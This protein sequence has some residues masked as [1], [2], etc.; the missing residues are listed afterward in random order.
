MTS[1][2]DTL[3]VVTADHAHT[4]AIVGYASRGNPILGLYHITSSKDHSVNLNM[5]TLSDIR[6]VHVQ[7]LLFGSVDNLST[8]QKDNI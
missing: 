3:I 5:K 4:M 6:T 8:I 2:D 1:A 7:V